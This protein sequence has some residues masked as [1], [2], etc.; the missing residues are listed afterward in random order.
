MKTKNYKRGD[1][2][3]VKGI[4]AHGPD[5]EGDY[6]FS[7]P[8]NRAWHLYI[9]KDQLMSKDGAPIEGA[10]LGGQ[11]FYFQA[12]VH[13][14]P[15]MDDE[16][17][18]MYDQG[19]R[20]AIVHRFDIVTAAIEPEKTQQPTT[21]NMKTETDRLVEIIR[22]QENMFREIQEAARYALASPHHVQQTVNTVMFRLQVLMSELEKIEQE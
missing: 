7:V 18:I 12:F 8:S 9:K 19:T 21:G 20:S 2:I 14:G 11:E 1:A 15:D 10:L 6:C 5:G 17:G 16:Y 22:S 4:V 13:S 3:T